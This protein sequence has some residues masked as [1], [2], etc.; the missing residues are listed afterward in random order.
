MAPSRAILF[1]CVGD[2]YVSSIFYIQG[3]F[4][5]TS[6]FSCSL[7]SKA[8]FRLCLSFC[9]NVCTKFSFC[10]LVAPFPKHSS[11]FWCFYLSSQSDVV[12][13]SILIRKIKKQSFAFVLYPQ[14]FFPV[15][16]WKSHYLV[17][18]ELFQD[19]IGWRPTR[20]NKRAFRDHRRE[21]DLQASRRQ[22]KMRCYSG[23]LL[24]MAEIEQQNATAVLFPFPI[25]GEER[26]GP[27]RR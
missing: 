4:V 9:G 20:A 5:A 16:L 11:I 2:W 7:R 3:V 26:V 6:E 18:A 1:V 21:A 22:Q 24:R 19:W 14:P 25:V 23:W 15:N 12:V 13:S 17:D 27:R 10:P 8:H